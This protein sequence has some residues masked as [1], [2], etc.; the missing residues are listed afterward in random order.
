VKARRLL[1]PVSAGIPEVGKVT[2]ET[3]DDEE[4]RAFG[5]EISDLLFDVDGE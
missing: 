2:D 3:S 4:I 5:E 1:T